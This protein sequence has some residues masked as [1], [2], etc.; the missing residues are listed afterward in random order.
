MYFILFPGSDYLSSVFEDL[1]LRVTP[2]LIGLA[3]LMKNYNNLTDSTITERIP[4]RLV[5]AVRK[6]KPI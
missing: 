2:D 5:S 6:M 1:G 4:Q 3:K